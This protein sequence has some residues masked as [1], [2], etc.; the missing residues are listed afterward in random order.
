MNFSYAPNSQRIATSCK[1]S[2]LNFIS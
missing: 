1:F 2:I